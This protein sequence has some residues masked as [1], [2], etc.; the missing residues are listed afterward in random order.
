MVID[1]ETYK[2]TRPKCS[3]C[4]LK[5]WDEFYAMMRCK[6]SESPY[7]DELLPEDI[8]CDHFTKEEV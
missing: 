2:K 8:V 1:I 6:N 3:N 5:D 4:A 7:Y